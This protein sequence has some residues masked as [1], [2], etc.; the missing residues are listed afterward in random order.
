M[1]KT[2]ELYVLLVKER[3]ICHDSKFIMSEISFVAVLI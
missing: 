2:R 3:E 1:S